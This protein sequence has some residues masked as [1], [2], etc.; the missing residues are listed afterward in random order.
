MIIKENLKFNDYTDRK[1][2][3]SL[4]AFDALHIGHKK[5]INKLVSVSKK[6][7]IKS[8]V[9]TFK[10][11]PRTYFTKKINDIVTPN[12]LRKKILKN[13]GVDILIFI[14]FNKYIATLT[15]DEFIKKLNLL[16]NIKNIVV[17]DDFKFG[18][19][20]QGDIKLLKS[21][22]YKYGYKVV[23]L[24]KLKYK[25]EDV[26]SSR[27]RR[28]IHEGNI[29]LANRLL[30]RDFFVSGIVVKGKG[31][32]RQIGFPTLNLKQ[33]HKGQILPAQGV[34][35]SKIIIGR[36]RYWGMTYF[37]HTRLKNRFVIEANLFD[38]NR[39]I[40]NKKISIFLIKRLRN[41]FKVINLEELKRFLINDKKDAL[42]IIKQMEVKEK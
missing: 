14:K 40:Y 19:D 27:I 7:N 11:R 15:A 1:V 10:N 5:V 22:A 39:K 37:G 30:G 13:L 36:R 16:F 29:T 24:K 3:V 8:V 42:K 6:N 26:S 34:Y 17:G 32:G 4:G 31:I 2:N 41:D 18:K 35:V 12:E 25:G 9:F 33:E 23:A 21:R 28:L 20:K 38:F